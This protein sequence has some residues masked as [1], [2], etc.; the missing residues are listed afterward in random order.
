MTSRPMH[1]KKGQE[2]LQPFQNRGFRVK[3]AAPDLNFL[4]SGTAAEGWLRNITS[5]KADPGKI[6]FGQNLS[7][8]SRLAVLYKYGGI[9]I[10]SDVIILKSMA[11]LRNV[12]GAQSVDPLGQWNRLNNAVLVFEKGH[13]LVWEFIEEIARSFNGSQWGHNGP[14]LAT[15]VVRK[16]T[17]RSDVL[18]HILSPVAFY[19]V[20]WNQ[21]PK[22]FTNR[23]ADSVEGNWRGV[24]MLQM[25][26]ASYALH[27]WNKHTKNLCVEEGSII[28]QIFSK[29]CLLCGQRMFVQRK[30]YLIL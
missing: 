2:I 26:K 5:G 22:F 8:I 1:S 16:I 7:N 24:K 25:E 9:Y 13:P 23:T 27:L 3:A 28:H 6:G 29:C 20:N 11:K 10:D 4:F 14:Y 15:R 17:H 18:F 12:I 21:I 19:P 30:I